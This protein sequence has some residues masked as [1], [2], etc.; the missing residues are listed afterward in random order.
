[1]L[2]LE[3]YQ[4]ANGTAT[5]PVTLASVARERLQRVNLNAPTTGS[6]EASTAAEVVIPKV[7]FGKPKYFKPRGSEPRQ[8]RSRDQDDFSGPG[9]VA[10]PAVSLPVTER[11]SRPGIIA[12]PAVSLPLAERSSPAPEV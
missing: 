7:D 5:G 4:R 1:M 8:R 2:Q 6:A 10:S 12:S 9:I 11:A 3:E